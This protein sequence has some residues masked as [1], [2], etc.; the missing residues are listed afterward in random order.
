M[1]SPSLSLPHASAPRVVGLTG[2]IGCGKSLVRKMFEALGVPCIDADLVARDIH[3]NPAHP[4]TREIAQAFPGMLTAGGTLQ[5]GSLHGLFAVDQE[6]NRRLKAILQP[7]VMAAIHRWTVMQTAPYV[8]WESAL[9]PELDIAVDRVLVVDAQ[10]GNRMARI[11]HRNPEWTEQQIRNLLAIQMPR[12]AY[13]NAAQDVTAN[14]ESIHALQRQVEAMHAK[15]L[16][17]WG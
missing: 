1:S 11:A 8:I 4:A 6:A 9:L 5:R 7:H 12:D 10:D 3:Q 14:D 16:A 15:Y 2:G 17:M 13:L